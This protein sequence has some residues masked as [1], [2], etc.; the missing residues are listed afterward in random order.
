L[1]FICAKAE[2]RSREVVGPV[3]KYF[4]ERDELDQK[5]REEAE[6]QPLARE[7]M[8]LPTPQQ[9]DWKG[10]RMTEVVNPIQ[11]NKE[12]MQEAVRE[13]QDNPDLTDAAK[14]R[15]ISEITARHEE[16]HQQLVAERNAE[17]EDVG[18]ML[19]RGLEERF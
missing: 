17:Q 19:L 7:H 5:V 11:A 16:A 1:R 6:R 18:S 14:M 12:A 3:N 13:V 2:G 10:E 15:K 9:V 4:Q 8:S